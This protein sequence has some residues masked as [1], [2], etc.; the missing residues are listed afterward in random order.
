[1]QLFVIIENNLKKT[2]DCNMIKRFIVSAIIISIAFQFLFTS[3][4]FAQGP[5]IPCDAYILLDLDN[6]RVLAEKDA[7]KK[8]YPAST[9]KMM[10][11]GTKSA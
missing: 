10:T 5:N 8:I 6:G 7:S 11:D 4:A 2:R 3:Q 9:T 1:M